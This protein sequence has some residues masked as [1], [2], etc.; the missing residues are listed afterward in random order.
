MRVVP[1]V[2]VDGAEGVWPRAEVFL[3]PVPQDRFDLVFRQACLPG[4]R[5]QACLP[6]RRRLACLPGRRRQA[7]QHAI[8]DRRARTAHAT[9]AQ[10]VVETSCS[11]AFGRRKV[12]WFLPMSKTQAERR[13]KVPQK[14]PIVLFDRQIICREQSVLF[15]R[16]VR[17]PRIRQRMPVR[18]GS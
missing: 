13:Q 3:L 16:S 9:G 12:A 10:V 15:V 7:A 14:V 2:A 11:F 5:R 8:E 6:G 18:I 17:H 4:R 1:G